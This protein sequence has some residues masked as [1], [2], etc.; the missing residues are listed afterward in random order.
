MS[1]I[2]FDLDTRE[3]SVDVSLDV[4]QEQEQQLADMMAK[5]MEFLLTLPRKNNEEAS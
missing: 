5:F 3:V 1:K 2:I 4:N